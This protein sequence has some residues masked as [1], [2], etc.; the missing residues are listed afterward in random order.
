MNDKTKRMDHPRVLFLIKSALGNEQRRSEQESTWLRD[1]SEGS[2]YYFCHGDETTRVPRIDGHHLFLPVRED[3]DHLPAKMKAMVAWASR[4]TEF[5]YVVTMDD[6]VVVDIGRLNAFIKSHPDHFGNRWDGDP[7]HISGMLVGYSRQAFEI[8]ANVVTTIPDTGPDDLLVSR[9]VYEPFSGLNVM[10]DGERFR[11]Y[12]AGV[13]PITIAAEVR[14][15]RPGSMR[16]FRFDLPPARNR[17]SFCLYGNDPKYVQGA[18]IN[19]ELVPEFYPGWEA[20]F[21]TRDVAP[22]ILEELRALGAT[23]VECD[24]RNMMLARFLPFCDQGVVLSRDCDSRI[25][26]REVRAVNEWLETDKPAH[27]IR[28]HPE[29]IPG[30]AMIP[31][32]LWGSRLPFGEGL[33]KALEDALDDPQYSGWGGDQRWLVEKVWRPDGFKIHQY[34]QVDWMRVSWSPDDFCGMRHE[35]PHI[36][37]LPKEVVLFEGFFN[38]LNGLVNAL[39][40][41]GTEFRARWAVNN[42]L[43]HRFEDLFDP[44]PDIAIAEESGLGYWPENTDPLKGPLCYWYVSRRCGADASQIEDAYRYFISKLKIAYEE[45]PPPLGIHYRGLHHSA[46]VTP[47]DF[48]HWCLDQ[49]RARRLT[50]CFAM[51]DCGREEIQRILD[52]GGM[53]ITWGTATPLDQDLDRGSLEELRK[54]VGDAITLA[55]CQTVLTSFDETTIVDPARAFGREVIA[56][57][58]SREWSECWF[59]HNGSPNRPIKCEVSEPA[60]QEAPLGFSN[61]PTHCHDS[62]IPTNAGKR[63]DLRHIPVCLIGGKDGVP[64]EEQHRYWKDPHL[65]ETIFPHTES[66]PPMPGGHAWGCSAAHLNAAARASQVHKGTPV[67]L[68]EDDAV[69]TRWFTPI[70]EAVPEDADIIWLGRSIGIYQGRPSPSYIPNNK[71]SYQ[72]LDGVCQASHAVLLVTEFGKRAWQVCCE[73][74]LAGEMGAATDLV[75]SITGVTLCTQYTVTNP[76]FHQPD[77]DITMLPLPP[78][79]QRDKII[80]V[81]AQGRTGNQLFQFAYGLHLQ[82][83]FGAV[84]RGNLHLLSGFAGVPEEVTNCSPV[85]TDAII[86]DVDDESASRSINDPNLPGIELNGFFQTYGYFE[87]IEGKLHP[88]LGPVAKQP[89]IGVHVRR[90]DYVGSPYD[91]HLPVTYYTAAVR[92]IIFEYPGDYREIVV[93]SDD[94]AWCAEHLLDELA[95]ILPSRVFAGDEKRTLLEMKSMMGMVITN[96]TFSWWGAWLADCPTVHPGI[97]QIPGGVFEAGLGCSRHYWKPVAVSNPEHPIAEKLLGSWDQYNEGVFTCQKT[98]FADGWVCYGEP[99]KV[100]PDETI[101]F[102]IHEVSLNPDGTLTGRTSHGVELLYRRADKSQN[103]GQAD[104]P[105]AIAE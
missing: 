37:G 23:V 15:F 70:L 47:V 74:A 82:G 48:A 59:R 55:H 64:R 66:V 20:I 51:A 39:L 31:G 26:P 93:F 77:Y 100:G 89:A 67:L 103:P 73:R 85:G 18:I 14:P 92:Q 61:A 79:R 94:P 104:L 88:L 1:I 101:R 69:P 38:R 76:L 45:H 90:G 11:P 17:V 83:K 71:S 86:C 10:T 60:V 9:A 7:T 62:G 54:F 43:P 29:H 52:K 75:G 4:K 13:T 58:G 46:R 41:H 105:A 19:A 12:G 44:S 57:S 63:I 53:E 3:Y 34:D 21:H 49:L 102:G 97:W 35:V 42:H 80:F 81:R 32:G 25:S 98:F 68:L 96:S 36:I 8:L 99:W 56:Y 30:W 24:Y 16:G 84:L 95:G 33:R 91:M 72:R 6:D 2:D 27:L 50:R 65:A 22:S 87:A 40:I 78:P 5:D 28:D